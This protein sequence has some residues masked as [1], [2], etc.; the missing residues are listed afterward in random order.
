MNV[1]DTFICLGNLLN[2]PLPLSFLISDHTAM[3]ASYDVTLSVIAKKAPSL[4]RH[5]EDLR[6]EP[7]DYLRPMFSSLF[8]DRLPLEHAARLMDVYAVEGDKIATRAAVGLIGVLEG[9]LYQG[10]TEDVVRN[11][12]RLLHHLIYNTPYIKTADNY[13]PKRGDDELR[14]TTLSDARL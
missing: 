12:N 11:L 6:V 10:G 1:T 2:R 3:T 9:K 14:N 4:A 5:L 8:C 13:D 7:H